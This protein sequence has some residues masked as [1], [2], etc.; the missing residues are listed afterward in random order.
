M[1]DCHAF[2]KGLSKVLKVVFLVIDSLRMA[3]AVVKTIGDIY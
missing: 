1:G 3:C 2:I